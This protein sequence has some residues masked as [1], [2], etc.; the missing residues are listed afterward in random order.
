[1]KRVHKNQIVLCCNQLHFFSLQFHTF[2][3][4]ENAC[5]NFANELIRLVRN[6]AEGTF[7]L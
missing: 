5:Y 7:F 3:L 1:M 6:A 2:C 4:I